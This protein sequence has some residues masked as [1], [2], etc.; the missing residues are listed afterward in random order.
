MQSQAIGYGAHYRQSQAIGY[1]TKLYYYY[2]DIAPYIV[3]N[4][5][6]SGAASDA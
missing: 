2:S 3:R 4:A 6:D 5:T 1:G